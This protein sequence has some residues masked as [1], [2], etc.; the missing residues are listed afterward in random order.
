MHAR[1]TKDNGVFCLVPLTCGAMLT[2][3]CGGQ[4]CEFGF[5]IV[6]LLSLCLVEV[7]DVTLGS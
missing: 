5:L 7:K 6:A 1:F 2:A 4:V 3:S